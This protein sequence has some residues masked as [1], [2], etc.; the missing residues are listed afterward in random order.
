MGWGSVIG[1]G[2]SAF[3][4]YAGLKEAR[5]NRN[6]QAGQTATSHQREV[7]DLIAAGLNPILSANKGAG[8][9]GGAQYTPTE[10]PAIAA[11]NAAN[12]Q[13]NLKNAKETQKNIAANT[14]KTDTDNAIAQVNKHLLLNTVPESNA[15]RAAWENKSK[16]PG[17]A[18]S[19][20][21]EHGLVTGLGMTGA[22]SIQDNFSKWDKQIQEF[23]ENL[24]KETKEN[25]PIIKK[26]L[27]DIID[28]VKMWI[29]GF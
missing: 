28:G 13:Q 15:N 21:K 17:D 27:G 1:G 25:Y 20:I 19:N 10:N 5:R 23:G 3:N 18:A 4:A 7:K 14:R 16:I 12:A 11:L 9:A 6:F 24:E 22:K 26:K 29:K 2:A 8:S